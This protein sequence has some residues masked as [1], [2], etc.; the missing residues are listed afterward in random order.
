[1]SRLR[2]ITFNRRTQC[3]KAWA[4]ELGISVSS[5]SVR[6]DAWTLEAA[7]TTPPAVHRTSDLTKLAREH[8]LSRILLEVRLAKGWPLDKALSTPARKRAA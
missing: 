4:A 7:L 3:L 8:G 2:M 1:M 6:L 5:L